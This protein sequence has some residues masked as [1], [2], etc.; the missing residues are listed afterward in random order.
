MSESVVAESITV[1]KSITSS[2]RDDDVTEHCVVY[3]GNKLVLS[4]SEQFT[5]NSARGEQLGE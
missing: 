2:E 5:Q 4:Q 3:G 1:A